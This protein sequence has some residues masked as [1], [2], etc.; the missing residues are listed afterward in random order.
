MRN[1]RLKLEY[2]KLLSPFAFN[3]QLAPLHNGDKAQ[4]LDVF[5]AADDVP[6]EFAVDLDRPGQGLPLVHFSAQHEPFLSQ[7]TPYRPPNNP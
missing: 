3:F 7:N 4:M 6:A 5:A 1:Q 2:R